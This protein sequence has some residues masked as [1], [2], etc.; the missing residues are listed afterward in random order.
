MAYLLLVFCLLWLAPGLFSAVTPKHKIIKHAFEYGDSCQFLDCVLPA[1]ACFGSSF[2]LSHLGTKPSNNDENMTILA[3]FLLA[4]CLLWLASGLLC[5]ACV[6]PPFGRF[7]AQVWWFVHVWPALSGLLLACL[8]WPV[9]SGSGL[10]CP[11]HGQKI[12]HF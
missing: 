6:L 4:S 8:V 7:A 2:R 9:L 3:C 1:L 12:V 10:L 5:L 11:G